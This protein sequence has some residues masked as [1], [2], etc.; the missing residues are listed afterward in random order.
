MDRTSVSFNRSVVYVAISQTLSFTP[1]ALAHSTQFWQ[2]LRSVYVRLIRLAGDRRRVLGQCM[3]PAATDDFSR[4]GRVNGLADHLS[5]PMTRPSLHLVHVQSAGRAPIE[6]N[7]SDSRPTSYPELPTTSGCSTARLRNILLRRVAAMV[8]PS[9]RVAFLQLGCK[10]LKTAVAKVWAAD[11][12]WSSG[13]ARHVIFR[14]RSQKYPCH[15]NLRRV[16]R[17]SRAR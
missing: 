6:K 16:C 15:K 7:V 12:R 9:W 14:D 2:C 10:Q 11:Q 5:I 8:L 3:Y 17:D 13:P 4:T 1:L